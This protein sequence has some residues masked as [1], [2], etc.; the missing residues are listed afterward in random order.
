MSKDW[1]EDLDFQAPG[2]FEDNFEDYRHRLIEF[3]IEHSSMI[4]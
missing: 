2:A 4:R 1:R 3:E